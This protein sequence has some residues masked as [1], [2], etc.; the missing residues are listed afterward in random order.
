MN[1]Q[2]VGVMGAMKEET[3]RLVADMRDVEV[4]T[5][6][7]RKDTRGI[8]R[9]YYSGTLYGRDVT[10]VFS[11]WGK[12]ASASTVTTLIDRF[13]TDLVV[14]SGVAGALDPSLNAGDVIIADEFIQYDLDP[15]PLFDRF[16]IP[17]PDRALRVTALRVPSELV[18][19]A[20]ASAQRYVT[21]SL[22]VRA[23]LIISGDR[24]IASR[25]AAE[26]LRNDLPHAQCVEM[27]GAAVAQVCWERD[28]PLTVVRVI[29][30][31]ADHC[32]TEDFSRFITRVASR[33]T[34]GVVRDLIA[35]V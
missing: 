35:H 16:E 2:R 18:E 6:G 14:F 10:V 7:G 1:V 20:V 24:F 34:A 9:V 27:E 5:I 4:T 8:E 31:K 19:L 25:E 23:G 22:Q 12:V 21:S 11:R 32:A 28:I 3:A 15:R 17:I 33:M 26:R 30:D 13:Q 29:S